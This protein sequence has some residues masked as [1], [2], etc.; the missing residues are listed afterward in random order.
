M[1]GNRRDLGTFVA[2][3]R[4][5]L[6]PSPASNP[7]S[8]AFRRTAGWAGASEWLRSHAK[9]IAGQKRPTES[10]TNDHAKRERRR[11]LPRQDEPPVH[12]R[13]KSTRHVPRARR[14]E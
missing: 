3:D 12:R 7:I 13:R 1:A 4:D 6:A 11:G 10:R 5:N 2:S 14:I 8:P 9:S